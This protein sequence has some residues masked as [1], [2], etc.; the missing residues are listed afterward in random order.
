MSPEVWWTNPATGQ[1]ILVPGGSDPIYASGAEGDIWGRIEDKVRAINQPDALIEIINE[2]RIVNAPPPGMPGPTDKISGTSLVSGTSLDWNTEGGLFGKIRD[3]FM[4]R[5]PA[6][7]TDIFNAEMF[8][9]NPLMMMMLMGGMGNGGGN[10]NMIMMMLMMSMMSDSSSSSNNEKTTQ[11]PKGLP[12][13]EPAYPPPEETWLDKL[14]GL[15]NWG[16]IPE[17][18]KGIK[19]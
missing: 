17:I 1:T 14:K 19:T 13:D 2:G 10:N 4:G 18:D 12:F 3:F 9:K 6:R 16:G 8:T 5:D 11:N 15:F 7:M